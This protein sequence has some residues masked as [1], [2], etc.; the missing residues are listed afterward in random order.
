MRGRLGLNPI[1][2]KKEIM[3]HTENSEVNE[4]DKQ[5]DGFKIAVLLL[6]VFALHCCPSEVRCHAICE[7]KEAT[8]D[9]VPNIHL[10]ILKSLGTSTAII[11]GLNH[12]NT[13]PC[14]QFFP[15]GNLVDLVQLRETRSKVFMVCSWPSFGGVGL[16]KKHTCC[17]TPIR[18]RC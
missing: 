5:K 14:G 1:P 2:R 18:G 8:S 15:S 4:K 3:K 9:N 16:R 13:G 17:V 7:C 10:D 6:D 11:W 12:R